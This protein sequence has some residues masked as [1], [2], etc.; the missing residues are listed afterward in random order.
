MADKDDSTTSPG[1]RTPR[2]TSKR[3]RDRVASKSGRGGFRP[4]SGRKRGVLSKQAQEAQRVGKLTGK[5][6]RELL[7][8]WSQRGVMTDESGKD[9]PL[10]A[11]Q[12]IACAKDCA[13]YYHPRLTSQQVTGHDKGPLKVDLDVAQLKG[14]PLDMITLL[15]EVLNLISSGGRTDEKSEQP[16]PSDDSGPNYADTIH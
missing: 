4:G 15:E 2:V 7:L 14:L 1:G 6:P 12:R 13:N 10:S 11:D 16:A 9:I 5:L 3:R 8:E